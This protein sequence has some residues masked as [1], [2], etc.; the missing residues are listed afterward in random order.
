MKA[1]SIPVVLMTCLLLF[2]GGRT[3]PPTIPPSASDFP[4]PSN[5]AVS[6]D[7]RLGELADVPGGRARIGGWLQNNWTVTPLACDPSSESSD[8]WS[9]NLEV[10]VAPFRLMITE[11]TN[12]AYAICV[13]SGGCIPPDRAYL[14]NN[15][16]ALDWR[17][18]SLGQRP[19]LLNW[20]LAHDF[21]RHYG[22]DLPTAGEYARAT[23]GD[24]ESYVQRS[25]LDLMQ[26]CAEA[27][28]PP[29]EC[30]RGEPPGTVGAG[31]HDVGAFG[32]YDLASNAPEWV[33][34]FFPP[35]DSA[36]CSKIV[37]EHDIPLSSPS[38]DARPNSYIHGEWLLAEPGPT[39][40]SPEVIAYSPMPASMANVSTGF[41]CA[42]PVTE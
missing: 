1:L 11:V 14:D 42:F 24:E 31:P 9:F 27:V 37:Y 3:S 36:L 33:R 12:D 17:D 13:D 19:V 20:D 7:P 32:H 41:R 40:T 28:P 38:P 8:D 21:C 15:G 34:G 18:S 39:I 26:E 2:C 6:Y 10:I 25:M 23:T 22:G 16:N 4:P 30:S 35:K 29:A 5:D